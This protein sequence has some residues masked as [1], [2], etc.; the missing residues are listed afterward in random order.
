[1]HSISTPLII[2]NDRIIYK[3]IHQALVSLF[4][5]ISTFVGYLIP[6]HSPRRTVV[7]LLKPTTERIRG[8]MPFTMVFV[9]KGT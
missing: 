3:E 4:N 7:V 6:S 1:M 9:R 5:D 2:S 8:F